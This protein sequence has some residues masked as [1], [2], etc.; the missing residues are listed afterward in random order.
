MIQL[1]FMP[2]N[3]RTISHH[4]SSKQCLMPA[5]NWLMGEQRGYEGGGGK[6]GT[7][8][9]VKQFNLSSFH[10]DGDPLLAFH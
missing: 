3:G 7:H 5:L 2:S 1:Y 10:Q 9:P 8:L 4:T 6:A